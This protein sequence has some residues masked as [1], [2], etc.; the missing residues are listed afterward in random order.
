MLGTNS[1]ALVEFSFEIGDPQNLFSL[2]GEGDVTNGNGSS[3]TSYSIF[4]R[5][6]K[7]EKIA[8]KIL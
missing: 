6:F 7:L 1:V 4:Y 5:F 2:F 8:V 3:S